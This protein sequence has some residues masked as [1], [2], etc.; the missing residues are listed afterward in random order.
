MAHAIGIDIGVTNV[1]AICV[2]AD[3]SVIARESFAT[4][5]D[6]PDW[7]ARVR[8]GLAQFE[9]RQGRASHIGLAAPGVAAPDGSRITWMRGRLA[10]VEGLCWSE[11]LSRPAPIIN[12]A[13]AALLGEVW[14]GAARGATN[15]IMLTL[16]TGVGG[17][18]MVDGQLLKGH[19]GRAGHLGHVTVD[20]D[21]AFDIVNTPGSLES[22]I[23]NY[24]INQRS[25]G[26]FQTTHELINAVQAKDPRA[27]EI[28]RRS[29]KA[30]A[31]S[32]ASLVNVLDP[33]IVILGGGIAAAGNALLKLLDE[34]F[35]PMEWKLNQNP[36]VQIALAQLG[37]YAG[38]LGAA[39]NA[40]RLPSN[41]L[42]PTN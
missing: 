28:W 42:K 6:S 10:E 41:E 30:L 27:T 2:S 15:A 23:G 5:A 36:G 1:K 20:M 33:E 3:G 7:P 12:D 26:A 34:I 4:H 13:Q 11:F 8:D 22:Q 14:Q 18:A 25:D 38:A 24:S 35:R 32:I 40:M 39:W 16:G 29:I 21:G 19:L 9:S 17:A 37:E 31:A